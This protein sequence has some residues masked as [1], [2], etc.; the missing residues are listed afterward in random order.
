MHIQLNKYKK[1]IIIL[2]YLHPVYPQT[3][4]LYPQPEN[5]K[6]TNIIQK[7]GNNTQVFNFKRDYNRIRVK[8]NTYN[9]EDTSMEEIL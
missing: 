7:T 1:S 4:F 9:I 3:L 6:I 5:A 2:V 8:H